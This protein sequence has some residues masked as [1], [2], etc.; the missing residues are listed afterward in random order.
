MKS[1]ELDD[2]EC[3]DALIEAVCALGELY[4]ITD[5]GEELAVVAPREMLRVGRKKGPRIVAANANKPA[6]GGGRQE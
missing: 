5:G 4:V 6:R 2:L 3:L 1:V